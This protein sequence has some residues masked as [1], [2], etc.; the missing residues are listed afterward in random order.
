MYLYNI[1]IKYIYSIYLFN[2]FIQYIYTIYLQNIFIQYNYK[3]Y[4]YNIFA[5]ECDSL[6]FV[7]RIISLS[8]FNRYA[9]FFYLSN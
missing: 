7:Y 8:S 5:V 6:V 3:I 1:F 9:F 2:I 4:L